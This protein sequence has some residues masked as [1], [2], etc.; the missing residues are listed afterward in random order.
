MQLKNGSYKSKNRVSDTEG[1]SDLKDI[2]EAA[3]SKLLM[4]NRYTDFEIGDG[5]LQMISKRESKQLK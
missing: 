5:D 4:Y 2:C 1:K 3:L